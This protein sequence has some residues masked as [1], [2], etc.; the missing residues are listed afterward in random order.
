VE[1]GPFGQ[2]QTAAKQGYHSGNR[3][4]LQWCAVGV[5]KNQI[6]IGA[7]IGAELSA[8]LFLF[9]PMCVG[10]EQDGRGQLD[11][12]WAARFLCL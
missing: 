6:K 7:V 3:I 12:P 4:G 5:S 1:A 9:P 11:S 8:E 2:T 10:L